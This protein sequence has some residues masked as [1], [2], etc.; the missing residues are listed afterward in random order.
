MLEGDQST[1][2]LNEEQWMV[3]S[4]RATTFIPTLSMNDAIE[5]TWW[6]ETVGSNP[7][8]EHINRQNGRK[9]QTGHLHDNRLVMVSQPGRVDWTHLV[10]EEVSSETAKLPALGPMSPDTLDPFMA[11][12]KNWL[13]ESP[14]TNRLAFGAALG[15]PT[16]DTQTGYKEIQQYIPAVQLNRQG[17][18]DFFYRINHP[19][20]SKVR[21]G[22]MINRLNSWTVA[23]LGTVE[24]TVE[25]TVSR[26]AANIQGQQYICRLDLDINTALLDDG[27]T[28]DDAYS[29]FQELVEHGREIASKGD[30]L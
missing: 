29:I 3:G 22:T 10:A 11:I 26:V 14:S 28:K 6:N 27:V 18:T 13:N 30:V 24:V 23:L 7:D 15:R 5:N 2:G 8:D 4:L 1:S 16:T 19:K 21:P 25:P 12:V 20:E 17:I 9:E